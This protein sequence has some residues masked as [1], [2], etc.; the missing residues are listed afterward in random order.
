M[1]PNKIKA[2]NLVCYPRP[3]ASFDKVSRA[4]GT[5]LAKRVVEV[6][7]CDGEIAVCQAFTIKWNDLTVRNE[8]FFPRAYITTMTYATL[9]FPK[10][11]KP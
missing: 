9:G 4:T 10:A 2:E 8:G 3:R 5:L 6:L 1:K 7:T 11:G